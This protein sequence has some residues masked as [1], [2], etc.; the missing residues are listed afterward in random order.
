VDEVCNN[1]SWNMWNS[2][3]KLTT[4]FR[5]QLNNMVEGVN[6]IIKEAVEG[7][8]DWG[9]HYVDSYLPT[10]DGH[11]W[12]EPVPDFDGKTDRYVRQYHSEVFQDYGSQQHFWS[13]RSKWDPP[14]G[15][16]GEG[17]EHPIKF[18]PDS[19]GVD[20]NAERNSQLLEK[21][22]PDPDQRAKVVS[23]EADPG[24]FNIEAFESL[25]SFKAAVQAN[26]TDD[27]ETQALFTD[28]SY[29]RIW[30]P[31]GSGQTNMANSFFDKIKESRKWDFKGGA[32]T[33]DPSKAAE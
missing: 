33:G 9:V 31:K 13:W 27:P 15:P 25:E 19:A 24:D 22:V 26:P 1:I 18:F 14:V 11:K 30:H 3:V 16:T 6:S 32:P 5:T 10:F 23:G 12:C 2:K 4:D 17:D 21:L 20:D 8:A 7:M 29:Y 28:D